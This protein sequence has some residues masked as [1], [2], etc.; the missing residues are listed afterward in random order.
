MQ[1]FT[2]Y[3]YNP[4]EAGAKPHYQDYEIN[5]D[6]CG[7]MV[8]HLFLGSQPAV[9]PPPSAVSTRGAIRALTARCVY[10]RCSMH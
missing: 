7:P 9:V 6:E 4:D 8:R 3:R 1:T 10:H 2:V 5:L